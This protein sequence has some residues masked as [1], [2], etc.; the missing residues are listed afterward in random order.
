MSGTN[1]KICSQLR[2]DLAA[3]GEP[4]R[5]VGRGLVAVAG[6]ETALQ[7]IQVVAVDCPGQPLSSAWPV[8]GRFPIAAR[9]FLIHCPLTVT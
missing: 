4:A 7:G 3:A 9:P 1:V 5:R 6:G 8:S 2:P